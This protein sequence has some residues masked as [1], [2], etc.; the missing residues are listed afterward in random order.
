MCYD[1]NMK[2][3]YLVAILALVLVV[4]ALVAVPE[5]WGP[6][7]RFMA[8]VLPSV[9]VNYANND[10][11][12]LSES[13]LRENPL[14]VKAAE[15]KAKDMAAR[16]YFSHEGPN[17]ET[18]WSWLDKVGYAYVYAGENLAVNFF[19]S[20]DVHRAW[21]NS[22]AHRENLLD[23]RFT[24]IGVGMAPGKFEGRDSI[25]VVEFFG[26]TVDSLAL[27]S[28]PASFVDNNYRFL[29]AVSTLSNNLLGLNRQLILPVL[30]LFGYKLLPGKII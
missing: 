26:S 3:R 2:A 4:E 19:D 13:S 5:F 20:A 10:R 17:G 25:Y 27:S 24:E 14:L 12:K 18:P 28:R 29:S 6:G 8:A 11:H 15:L 21:M 7:R 1:K 23:K 30:E 9:V 16:G 22:P